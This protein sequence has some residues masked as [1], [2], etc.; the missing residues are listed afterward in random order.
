MLFNT[1]GVDNAVNACHLFFQ[2][3]GN[4]PPTFLFNDA[5]TAYVSPTLYR[6]PPYYPVQHGDQLA[7]NGHCLIDTYNASVFLTQALQ[8]EWQYPL[9]FFSSFNGAQNIYIK[10]TSVYGNSSPWIQL[11]SWNVTNPPSSDPTIT[12]TSPGATA[13]GTVPIAGA[14]SDPNSAIA[15]VV[16]YI[17]GLKQTP[18]A[19]VNNTAHTYTWSWNTSTSGTGQ[20]TITVFATDSDS[21]A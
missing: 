8:W 4:P 7:Y 15:S 16:V 2:G 13:T 11:G 20:H 19:T 6:Y 1:T 14:V 12:I 5:G 18:A 9:Y 17:D 3:Q 21:T 10:L